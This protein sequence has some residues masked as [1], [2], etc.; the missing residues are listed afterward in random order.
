MDFNDHVRRLEGIV[1]FYGN[2]YD[3][4]YLTDEHLRA[5]VLV[6]TLPMEDEI[7]YARKWY[8]QEY[9]IHDEC[10]H[11]YVFYDG[12]SKFPDE[13]T[14]EHVSE[15][16]RHRY[17]SSKRI[18]HSQCSC[19]SKTMKK[20]KPRSERVNKNDEVID[21]S[22]DT[23]ESIEMSDDD[24]VEENGPKEFSSSDS[25]SI[26]GDE[27]VVVNEIFNNISTISVAE[28]TIP[29]S[30]ESSNGNMFSTPTC[31]KGEDEFIPSLHY[32]NTL[33]V[34]GDRVRGG[35]EKK[36]KNKEIEV[37]LGCKAPHEIDILPPHKAKNKGSGKRQMS[38]KEKA[39]RKTEKR[40]RKCGNCKRWVNHNNR[41]CNLL[42]VEDLPSDSDERETDDEEV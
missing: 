32:S 9:D 30:G 11:D 20:E 34:Q 23:K 5:Y 10:Q 31:T 36:S 22:S 16:L 12:R 26:C 42:F 1:E 2:R 18:E 27:V 3:S 33:G 15:Q 29:T 4:R 38:S 14:Y 8:M 25:N 21:T 35:R 13:L 37:L 39:V 41:T 24:T 6:S 19:V 17:Y 40:K 7:G 28:N